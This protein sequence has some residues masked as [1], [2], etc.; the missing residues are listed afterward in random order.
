MSHPRTTLLLAALA[1]SLVLS[2]V[3]SAHAEGAPASGAAQ[4]PPSV[5]MWTDPP[6]A[7]R[8]AAAA[9]RSACDD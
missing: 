9:L 7:V 4:L 8:V 1:G 3:A 6:E 5:M 2:T